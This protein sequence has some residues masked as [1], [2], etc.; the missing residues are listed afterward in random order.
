ML[1]CLTDVKRKSRKKRTGKK[2]IYL[3]RPGEGK[4]KSEKIGAEIGDGPRATLDR[5][6]CGESHELRFP[7]TRRRP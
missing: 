7:G 6:L 1:R 5:R 2:M 4:V 3:I